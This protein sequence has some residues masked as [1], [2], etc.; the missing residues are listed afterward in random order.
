MCH[1]V[2]VAISA[3]NLESSEDEDD[4]IIMASSTSTQGGNRQEQTTHATLHLA[5]LEHNAHQ[6]QVD[7]ENA[8]RESQDRAKAK[9]S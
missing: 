2:T 4:A 1:G 6:A 8:V 7:I 9:V 3:R 5:Q